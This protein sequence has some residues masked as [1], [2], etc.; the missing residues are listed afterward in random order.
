MADLDGDGRDDAVVSATC[1][2]GEPA[3]HVVFGE[4]PGALAPLG[5]FTGDDLQILSGSTMTLAVVVPVTDTGGREFGVARG[6][7][8]LFRRVSRRRSDP[9]LCDVVSSPPTD[10]RSVSCRM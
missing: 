3:R 5:S 10:G 1:T 9:L 2:E 7:G 8:W 4:A 6:T